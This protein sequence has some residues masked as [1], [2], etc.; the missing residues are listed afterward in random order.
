MHPSIA[1]IGNT[2]LIAAVVLFVLYRRFR[3]NFGR[4]PLRPTRMIF[5]M[6][7]LCIIGLL[8]LPFA[9][10]S[11]QLALATIAGLVLG[12]GLAIWGAS[13]TRFE[14]QDEQIYYI[15][16]TY[17]GMAVSAL[18]LGRIIYRFAVLSPMMFSTIATNNASYSDMNGLSGLSHNPGTRL[19]FFI[20]IGYYVYYYGYVLRKAKHLKPVDLEKS[21]PS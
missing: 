5:R 13:R 21:V 10:L 9:L 12:I 17:T 14:K 6:L 4:Q 8:L 15:P 18:F 16:H 20:L 3:R 11:V 19:I 2:I 7:I 1:N